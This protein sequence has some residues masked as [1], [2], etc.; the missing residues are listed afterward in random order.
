MKLFDQT[1]DDRRDQRGA[2]TVSHHVAEEN[3]PLVVR[4]FDDFVKIP[5]HPAGGLSTTSSIAPFH[6]RHAGQDQQ[7]L[8]RAFDQPLLGGG[9]ETCHPQ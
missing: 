2:D 6:L 3:S 9:S 4:D 5:A 1:L 7:H 8:S